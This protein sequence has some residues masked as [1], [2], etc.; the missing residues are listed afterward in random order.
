MPVSSANSRKVDG[1]Q[2]S[3]A[4]LEIGA[5]QGFMQ[6]AYGVGS[7]TGQLQTLQ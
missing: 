5:Q 7:T 4:A 3:V 2:T 1:Q 6:L